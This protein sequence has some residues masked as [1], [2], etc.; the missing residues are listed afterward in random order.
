MVPG[1]GVLIGVAADRLIQDP[2][3]SVHPVALYGRYVSWLEGRLYQPT[4]IAGIVFSAAATIP[5]VAATWVVSRR[6]PEMALAVAL[7]AAL[8]GSTL[9]RTGAAM[10]GRLEAGDIA[11]AREL[12]PWL[13]SRDPELLD[14]AGMA[15]A[16]VESLAENTCDASSAP[17][18]WAV[19]G[20]PGVVAHRCL[21]TLDAMVGYTSPRYREFGWACARL[22]DVAAFLPARVTA[23]AHLGIAAALGRGGQALRAWRE[24][25][26]HHP[27]PN[28]GPVEATAAGTLGV[29]LGGRTVYPH[30]VEQRPV[31]GRGPAPTTATI[32]QAIRLSTTT[33]WV[34]A[35]IGVALRA[36]ITRWRLKP[37]CD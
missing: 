14:A 32:T 2:P 3:T 18:L 24:D 29:Q 26:P 16:T 4:K 33:Q 19:L 15:R 5:P 34:I 31:M 22:D 12:V 23:L 21:N 20:A 17:L 37:S 10:R 7:W 28:A 36:A 6:H 13:C 30:G 27:S 35:G 8:G 1:M 11:A 9:T 25:A